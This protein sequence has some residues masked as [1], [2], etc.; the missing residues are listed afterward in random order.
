[1]KP[2]LTLTIENTT[3][4]SA[5]CV[6]CPREQITFE[7]GNMPQKLFMKSI[8]EVQEFY[9]KNNNEIKYLDFGGM[10]EP[11]LDPEL[12]LKMK[13]MKDN[14]P[15]TKINLTTNAQLLKQKS[16]ILCEYVDVLKISNYG[17]SKASFESIHRGS[18]IYEEVKHNLEEFLNIPL[19]KR[20]K[21]IMSFL[22]LEQNQGEEWDWLEFWKSKCEEIYIW[23]PHN[24]AGAMG[25]LHNLNYAESRSCG[26]PGN[27]FAI[28]A[29]G[30]V[31]I[32][33][34]DFNRE[35]SI[36]NISEMSFEDIYYG[37]KLRK[38]REMHDNRAFC[39]S[40]TICEVCDQIFDRHDALV[41]SSKEDFVV[42]EITT[43]QA[44][45]DS[46]Q[47]Y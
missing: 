37:E 9:R 4:C 17:F 40:G 11:L 12:K 39:K 27:D 35:L 5:N 19:E 18:L 29:N 41:Y 47:A 26:R 6:M 20:P 25:G 13:W 28:R 15:A 42:G 38:I 2:F 36:G 32:C 22:M 10:G 43:N 16:D 24:W 34:W 14:Y 44:Y 7:K 8:K 21:V 1:M 30:D 45:K 33:C 3:Y 23:K 31:S 46:N